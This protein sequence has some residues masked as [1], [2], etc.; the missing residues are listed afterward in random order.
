MTMEALFIGMSFTALIFSVIG[1]ILGA[2]A[3]IIVKAM[4][5]STHTMT[6]MPA[7][8]A[9]K[10]SMEKWATD[11]EKFEEDKKKYTEELEENMPE[12]APSD[13]DRK[14]HAF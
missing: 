7:E 10:E 4:E 5:K 12:F 2:Y 6:Y 11:P 3:V 13:E 1:L 8:S 14:V 9:I